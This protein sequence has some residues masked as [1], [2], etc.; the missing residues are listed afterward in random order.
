MAS[1]PITGVW[2]GAHCRV[3]GQS[4]WCM[5]S[6]GE[7]E[8]LL[9]LGHSMEAANLPTFL[10]FGN[11]KKSDIC[12]ISLQKITGGHETGGPRANLGGCAPSRPHLKPPLSAS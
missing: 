5:G 4:P 11:A 6:G 3:Q 7:A 8:A 10:K 9:V 1:E 2:D 12:V